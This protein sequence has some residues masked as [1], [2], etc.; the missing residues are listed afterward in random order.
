MKV[1]L[2]EEEKYEVLEDILCN[3]LFVIGGSGLELQYNEDEYLISRG[4]MADPKSVCFEDILIQMLKDG[5][6][7]KIVDIEGEG[8]YTKEFDLEYFMKEVEATD[9]IILTNILN[10]NSDAY[11]SFNALQ[12]VLYNDL[13]FG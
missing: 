6:K 11:D 13:I 7:L 2:T 3:G 10:E 12:Y 4:K 9:P 1:I 5:Y 8:E